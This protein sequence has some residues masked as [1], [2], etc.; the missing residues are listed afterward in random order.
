MII[1]HWIYSLDLTQ[2]VMLKLFTFCIWAIMG[3]ASSDGKTFFAPIDSIKVFYFRLMPSF[4]YCNKKTP[5]QIWQIHQT[6][7]L[8]KSVK[9]CVFFL[10]KQYFGCLCSKGGVHL[11]IHVLHLF[12]RNSTIVACAFFYIQ[13][14]NKFLYWIKIDR[15]PY[16][17]SIL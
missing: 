8:N 15:V 17:K 12:A 16:A 6:S 1:L 4:T 10:S 5:Y 7:Q 9:V 14:T 3:L 11:Y 13:L 2:N